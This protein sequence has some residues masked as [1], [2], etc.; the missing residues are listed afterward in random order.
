MLKDTFSR[1]FTELDASYGSIPFKSYQHEEGCYVPDG[2][3]HKWATSVQ[4][5][6]LAVFGEASPH[7]KNFVAMYTK[8]GGG[9]SSVRTLRALFQSAK[10]DFEGGYVFDVDLRVSGGSIW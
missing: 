4:N 8:C 1:R 10:E 3:W 6:I 7:Y 5:L 2:Q 9:D